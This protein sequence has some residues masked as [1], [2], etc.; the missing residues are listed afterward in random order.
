M[1][2]QRF[3]KVLA[4]L[5]VLLLVTA[6]INPLNL[7]AATITEIDENSKTGYGAMVYDGA[8]LFDEDGQIDA[9]LD[10]AYSLTE[11]GDVF[12]VTVA[13][14]ENPYGKNE[15]STKK[16]GD[17]LY[18]TYSNQNSCIMFIID[19]HTRYI[20]VYRYGKVE[21]T[22]TSGKC[23]SITDNLYDYASDKEYYLCASKAL[24]QI[25]KVLAGQ[26]IAE[27]MK[28]VSNLF[29][30]FVIG[31]VVMYLIALSKSKVGKPSD[32]EMLKYAAI[33]FAANN[34][35]DVVT[36]TTKTYCP[37]SSGSG[38]GGRSGGGGGFRG[39]GGGGH[40]F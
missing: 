11:Y 31:F 25:G 16:F 34:P 40:R 37:R 6:V 32:E 2:V 36:G 3:K 23:D 20:Y 13:S 18:L 26:H 30:A 15:S 39:G 1:T 21:S 28:V 35:S 27:P 8:D 9:L 4:F 24:D 10:K 17:D 14:G 19:M 22:L 12:V 7:Q 29:I 5:F 38:R 33:S